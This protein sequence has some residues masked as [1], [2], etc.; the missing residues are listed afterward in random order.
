MLVRTSFIEE[1]S[2]HLNNAVDI[3]L[4]AFM[5]RHKVGDEVMLPEIEKK[6]VWPLP[7]ASTYIDAEPLLRFLILQER[8]DEAMRIASVSEKDLK[9]LKDGEDL[10]KTYKRTGEAKKTSVKIA[11]MNAEEKKKLFS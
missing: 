3:A 6:V 4:G 8:G 11:D 7:K 5:F 10:M 9:T 2:N 1:V